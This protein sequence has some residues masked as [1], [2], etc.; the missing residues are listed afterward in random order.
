[1]N[2]LRLSDQIFAQLISPTNL[3]HD[4]AVI[5]IDEFRKALARWGRAANDGNRDKGVCMG[6]FC[7]VLQGSNSLARG[8]II[9]SGT[10]E[11]AQKMGDPA[12]AAVF[13]R[14]SIKPTMLD[15]LSGDDLQNFFFSLCPE[16]RPGMPR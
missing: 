10:Q 6:G 12:F 11:L 2:D 1:M 14:L 15:W 4:N 5:Q 16:L 13:R 7:E 8:F 3:R 9:L